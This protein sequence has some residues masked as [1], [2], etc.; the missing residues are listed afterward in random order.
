MK[1]VFAEPIGVDITKLEELK[2]SIEKLGHNFEYYANIPPDEEAL[3]SRICDAEIICISNIP[4]NEKILSKCT[5]LKYLN[6]AFTGTDHIDIEYCKKNNIKVS[7]AAGYSTDAVSELVIGSAITLYRN[8]INNDSITRSYGSIKNTKIGFEIHNKTVGIVGTGKIGIKTAK[9]FKG[10]NCKILAYNRT[11][12]HED[13][14]EYSDLETIFKQSDIISL[15][16]P[17][18]SET[19]GIINSNLLSLMKETA[20]IINTARGGIIDYTFLSQ[21]L[22]ENKILAAAIDVYEYE[23]PLQKQHPILNAKNTL[24]L[25]HIGYYTIE[26]MHKRFSIVKSNLLAY[27][28]GEIINQVI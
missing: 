9:L 22:N 20:I 1:I 21:L 14:V 23:P 3:T 7:N 15:H 11:H 28:N 4:L 24:L 13:I 25:P 8:F 16:L 26:A 27:L 10:F 2:V 18:T 19:K 12:R 17:L 6:I 5:N